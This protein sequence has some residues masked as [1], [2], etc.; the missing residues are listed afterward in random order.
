M[1]PYFMF[2][3]YSGNLNDG[4]LQSRPGLFAQ[5]AR[6]AHAYVAV[7]PPVGQDGGQPACANDS[8]WF[9]LTLSSRSTCRVVITAESRFSQEA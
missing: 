3:G 9:S 4:L 2:R 6:A 1:L 5:V 7:R 8:L